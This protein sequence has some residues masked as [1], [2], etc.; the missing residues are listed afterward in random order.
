[1]Q[2]IKRES[3]PLANEQLRRERQRRGWSRASIADQ[4]GVADPKT[5]G[6][7]ERG[8]AF[9]S[10]YFLQRLCALFEMPAEALGLWKNEEQPTPGE[11]TPLA[12]VPPGPVQLLPTTS[13]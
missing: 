1:M 3:G 9:P 7:W 13:F 8:D 6:R 10:A 11:H 2:Q 4:I 5:I 12:L